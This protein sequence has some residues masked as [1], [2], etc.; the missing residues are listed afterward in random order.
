MR[1]EDEQWVKLYTR[2]TA[3]WKRLSWEG[4]ALLVLLLRK[5]DRAGALVTSG[6][7][8]DD[9]AAMLDMPTEVVAAGLESLAE[10][11]VAVVAGDTVMLPNFLAAQT[12][13]QS[14]KARK[15]AQRERDRAEMLAAGNKGSKA[16]LDIQASMARG[17]F[18]QAQQVSPAVTPSVTGCHTES[19]T[20]TSGHEEKR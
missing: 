10:R 7:V 9:V 13:R 8:A 11:G 6:D 16:G 3:T 15:I 14:D 5:V 19:P 2:D 4:K 1:W 18:I 12:T 17:S 20:V